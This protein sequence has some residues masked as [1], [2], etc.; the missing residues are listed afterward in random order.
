MDDLQIFITKLIK[1]AEPVLTAASRTTQAAEV[2]GNVR[3]TFETAI[4]STGECYGKMHFSI[5]KTITSAL[6][7]AEPDTETSLVNSFAT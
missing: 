7:L 1:T 2:F 4:K 3:S 5:S 6:K